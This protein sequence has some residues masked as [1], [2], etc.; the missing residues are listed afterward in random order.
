MNYP[1]VLQQWSQARCALSASL[2]A[3]TVG[4]GVGRH[5]SVSGFRWS[6]DLIVTVAEAL[7]GNE[8]ALVLNAAGE[9]SVAVIACDLA[10]DVAVLR[11]DAPVAAKIKDHDIQ[12]AGALHSGAAVA[13]AG[14]SRGGSLAGFGTVQ[15][16]G[17]AWSSRRGGAIDQRLEFAA[18]LDARFEGALVA[19]FAGN[20]QAMLVCGPRGSWLGIPAAT[21]Q[22]V[23]ASVE[24]HGY[25]P[26]PYLGVRLQLLWLDQA[27]RVRW[28]R[29]S[30][31]VVVLAGV[32]PGSPAETAELAPGDLLEAIDGIAVADIE[33]VASH[34]A[35]S[36]PGRILELGLRRR[37]LPETVKIE[38]S[39]WRPPER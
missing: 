8:E 24:R 25:L 15:L 1:G 36:S 10:T 2:A 20:V 23:V 33:E 22:R 39:E 29:H 28:G 19:D 30:R 26:R 4:I 3:R 21:I 37:G 31:A 18:D 35:Q 9:Q 17:P 13:F 38:V 16:A 34:L 27:T 7:D 32:E 5:R 6:T 12:A 14:Y 11:V